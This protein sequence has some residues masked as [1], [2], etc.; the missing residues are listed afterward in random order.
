MVT[1]S[2]LIT[3]LTI[4]LCVLFEVLFYQCFGHTLELECFSDVPQVT[5]C[6]CVGCI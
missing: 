3:Y 2:V 5:Q 4:K 1:D 6:V